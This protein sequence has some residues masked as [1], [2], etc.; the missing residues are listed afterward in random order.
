MPSGVNRPFGRLSPCGG[1]V[2]YALL[3]RP[4]LAAKILL[5]RAAARLA[6][7]RP[8]ASVYPEPGS[9][10]SLYKIVL[11]SGFSGVQSFCLFYALCLLSI[12]FFSN[13]VGEFSPVESCFS[14]RN[15][16]AKLR[17][18]ALSLQIFFVNFSLRILDA[19][20][21]N[22]EFQCASL[23]FCGCKGRDFLPFE[24]IFLNVFCNYFSS[25]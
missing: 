9:N 14:V 12:K 25:F 17:T 21:F 13:I 3:T 24:K 4:P 19:R 16:D 23:L 6:C 11:I 20:N 7:V 10:S 8:A 15:N 2:A 22:A 18:F 1:Q 5:S